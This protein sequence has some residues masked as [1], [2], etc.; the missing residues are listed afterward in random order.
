MFMWRSLMV[1]NFNFY[2]VE[3]I[4]KPVCFSK[5]EKCTAQRC[6]QLKRGNFTGD[7][8]YILLVYGVS[9]H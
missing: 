5:A 7:A 6:F 3:R 1:V 4:S 9:R 2:G 8:Q